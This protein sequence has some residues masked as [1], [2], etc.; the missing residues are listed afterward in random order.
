MAYKYL[1]YF[2][3]DHSIFNI[4]CKSWYLIFDVSVINVAFYI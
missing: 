2:T 1:L 4:D 3:Y